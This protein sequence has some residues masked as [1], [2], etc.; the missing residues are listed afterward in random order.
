MALIVDY[1]A[2]PNL[3]WPVM[4]SN[5]IQAGAIDY[6]H[7]IAI[8]P[9]PDDMRDAK[10]RTR[11][12]AKRDAVIGIGRC[13]EQMQAKDMRYVGMDVLAALEELRNDERVGESTRFGAGSA[14][15]K[16]NQ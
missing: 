12:E 11:Y 10:Y 14:L 4:L 7:R 15:D 2:Q 13:F 16:W 8:L 9:L 1:S 6:L 3:H 5:L